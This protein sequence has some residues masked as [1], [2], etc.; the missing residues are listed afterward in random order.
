MRGGNA[1]P[2]QHPLYQGQQVILRNQH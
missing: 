2:D 1:M